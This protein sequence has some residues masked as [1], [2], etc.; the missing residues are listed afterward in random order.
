MILKQSVHAVP[1][2]YPKERKSIG[3]IKTSR[4]YCHKKYCQRRCSSHTWCK[5]LHHRIW[6]TIRQ[7]QT[8]R[9]LQRDAKT[10]NNTAI[11]KIIRR[12]KNVKVISKNVK[13]KNS[14]CT[15]HLISSKLLHDNIKYFIRFHNSKH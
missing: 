10:E 2:T 15:Y 13:S 11:N 1:L 6:K 5:R 12:F 4:I 3:W 7:Y 14:F 8:S 9:H